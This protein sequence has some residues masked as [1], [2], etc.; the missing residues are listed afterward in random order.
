MIAEHA[1]RAP[2]RERAKARTKRK[3]ILL[4]SGTT[5][6]PKGA[7]HS[8][9]GDGGPGILKAILDRTPWRAEE[10]VVIVAPMF[11]AWGFS[12]L[13]FADRAGRA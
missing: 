1:G 3:V 7:K 11:H 6:S 12:Q 10:P 9:G 2:K 8:G 5:G 4:T 13:V